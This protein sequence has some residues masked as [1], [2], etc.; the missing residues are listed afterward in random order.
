MTTISVLLRHI[1]LKYEINVC[2]LQRMSFCARYE[3]SLGVLN[4]IIL[5]MFIVL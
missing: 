1:W 5:T 2:Y 4:I 3:T